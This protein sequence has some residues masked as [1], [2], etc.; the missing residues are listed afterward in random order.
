LDKF[1]GDGIMAVFNAPLSIENHALKAV[2]AAWAIKQGAKDLEERI[3][4]KFGKLIA[5]GIGINTGSAII[6]NIGAKFRMDYTA[7]GDTVNTAARLENTAK[8]GQIL[9]GESTYIFVK[10]NVD[11]TYLGEI[12]VKGK[13]KSILAYELKNIMV[14][15]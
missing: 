11:V 1:I 5:F 13:A 15:E 8:P 6:G 2:Q 3:I 7:I 10:E 9:L 4:N 14:V 12:S